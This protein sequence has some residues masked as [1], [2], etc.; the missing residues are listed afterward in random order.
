MGRFINADDAN[1]LKMAQGKLLTA[2]LFAYCGNNP[3]MNIDPSGKIGFLVGLLIGAAVT[4]VIDG[5]LI[6]TTGKGVSDWVAAGITFVVDNSSLSYQ[7]S[8]GRWHYVYKG[9]YS[10]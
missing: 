10:N 7:D 5:I 8:Y 9:K 1:A 6:A 3:V 4:W 2:N